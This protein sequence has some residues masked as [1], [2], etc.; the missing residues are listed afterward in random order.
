M[1]SL[2]ASSACVGPEMKKAKTVADGEEGEECTGPVQLLKLLNYTP[3][4]V[5]VFH[6]PDVDPLSCPTTFVSC[7]TIRCCPKA[8]TENREMSERF[9]VPIVSP[10]EFDGIEGLPHELDD[11]KTGI[12]VSGIVA[13]FMSTAA[14]RCYWIGPVFAP[15]AGW[16][17]VRNGQ[18]QITGVRRLV[19]YPWKGPVE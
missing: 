16:N 11:G 10:P 9:G 5:T 1:S 2:S 15:D 8:Q 7:G 14:P 17:E 6:G 4:N 19:H 3:H 18:G 12:I 13:S